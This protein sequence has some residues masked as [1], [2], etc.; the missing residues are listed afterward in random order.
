V[1]DPATAE[2]PEPSDPSAWRDADAMLQQ[3]SDQSVIDALRELPDDMRWTLL[4]VDVEGLDIAEAATV[5]EV[6]P[7]TVKS[8][9]HRARA[10]LKTRLQAN[11]G[12]SDQIKRATNAG[13]GGQRDQHD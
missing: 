9:C 6:A 2:R 3:F 5:L 10:L 11:A 1:F 8:R 7:G 4:L 13:R 12:E